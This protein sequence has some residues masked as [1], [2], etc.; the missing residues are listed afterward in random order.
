MIHLLFLA[1]AWFGIMIAAL[2]VAS[3][4]TAHRRRRSGRALRP[5]RTGRRRDDS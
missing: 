3:L 4:W 1:F 2:L 5:P